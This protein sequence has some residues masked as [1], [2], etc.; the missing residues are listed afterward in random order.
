VRYGNVSAALK[1]SILVE[2]KTTLP[3]A[4][5]RLISIASAVLELILRKYI[6]TC[7]GCFSCVNSYIVDTRFYMV[8]DGTCNEISAS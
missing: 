1:I 4:R 8:N 7:M 2:F 6:K 3:A 5:I